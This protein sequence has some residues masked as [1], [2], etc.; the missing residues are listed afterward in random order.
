[1]WESTL[2]VFKS[3]TFTIFGWIF[4]LLFKKSPPPPSLKS[5]MH[6]I[7]FF[8]DN[9][10]ADI[11]RLILADSQCRYRYIFFCLETAPSLFC[12]EIYILVSF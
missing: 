6:N 2:P 7:V 11:F 3:V 9:R 8:T 12:E 4:I 5:G 1:M 10:Y